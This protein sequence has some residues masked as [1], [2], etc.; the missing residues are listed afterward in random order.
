MIFGITQSAAFVSVW[1]FLLS[2]IPIWVKMIIFNWMIVSC[3]KSPLARWVAYKFNYQPNKLNTIILATLLL[4]L[5]SIL[6]AIWRSHKIRKEK[7]NMFIP[8]AASQFLD[9]TKSQMFVFLCFQR[10][11]GK[12]IR[13]NRNEQF[14]QNT[15]ASTLILRTL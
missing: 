8:I 5:H 12:D 14:Y 1:S 2:C 9:L 7:E 6:R 11:K 3:L 4:K 10:A 15:G 13:R